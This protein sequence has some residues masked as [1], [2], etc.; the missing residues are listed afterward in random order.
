[1]LLPICPI[2]E[3]G[4]SDGIHIYLGDNKSHE[5]QGYG[6]ISANIPDGQLKQIHKVM[7]VLGIKKKLTSVS[8]ITNNDMKVEFGKYKCHA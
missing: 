2:I 8:T 1:M 6:V 4:N 5:V 7:Y 3:H